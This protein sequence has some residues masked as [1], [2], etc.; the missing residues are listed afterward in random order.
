MLKALATYALN[1]TGW[2]SPQSIDW[3]GGLVVVQGHQLLEGYDCA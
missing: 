2:V 3:E 1:H